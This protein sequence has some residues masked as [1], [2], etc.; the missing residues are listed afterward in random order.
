MNPDGPP[1]PTDLGPDGV[2][3]AHDADAHEVGEDVGLVLPVGLGRG[4]QVA[5]RHADGAQALARHRLDHLLHHLVAV[6]RPEDA[7]LAHLVEDA[8]APGAGRSG[9]LRSTRLPHGAPKPTR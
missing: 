3:D 7:R 9:V 6:P 5:V 8:V 4:G 2:L 1:R